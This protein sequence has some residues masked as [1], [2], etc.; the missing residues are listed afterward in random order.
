MKS[1]IFLS[2]LCSYHEDEDYGSCIIVEPHSFNK[3]VAR[4]RRT[5]YTEALMIKEKYAHAYFS[6][7]FDHTPYLPPMPVIVDV[8]EWRAGE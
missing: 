6:F 4:P 3:S 1:Q 8:V 7:C 5:F 2:S